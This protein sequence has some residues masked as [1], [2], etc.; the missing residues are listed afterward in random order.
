MFICL[1]AVM[2]YLIYNYVILQM[3]QLQK[4]TKVTSFIMPLSYLSFLT[5]IYCTVVTSRNERI[6]GYQGNSYTVTM[7]TFPRLSGCSGLH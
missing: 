2:F 1:C 6:Y 7:V 3:L 5:N 4:A